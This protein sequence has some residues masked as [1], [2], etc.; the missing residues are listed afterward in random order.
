MPNDILPKAVGIIIRDIQ[1]RVLLAKRSS[2][3]GSDAGKWATI[4]GKVYNQETFEAAAARHVREEIGVELSA[5]QMIFETTKSVDDTDQDHYVRVYVAQVASQ[6]EIMEPDKT[7]ALKWFEPH[8]LKQ[9]GDDEELAI[10]TLDDLKY[11]E[12]T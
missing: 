5:L 12:L 9:M 10:Y 4:G 2:T 8:L 3:A 1:G 6:P 7:V 11:L